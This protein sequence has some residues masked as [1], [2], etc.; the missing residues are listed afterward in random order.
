MSLST[1]STLTSETATTGISDADGQQYRFD[2]RPTWTHR[3][4]ERSTVGLSGSYSQVNY[5]GVDNRSLTDYRSGVV[6]L[7]ADRRLTEVAGLAVDI[8]YGRFRTKGGENDTENLAVQVGGE[9]R[10]SETLGLDALVGLRQTEAR[11]PGLAG[12]TVSETSSGP[13]YTVGVEKRLARGGGLRLRAARDLTPSGSAEVLDTTS[14]ELGYSYPVN[15]RLGLDFSSRAFRNRLP[16]GEA[17]RSD[18]SYVGA[19]MGLTYRFSPSWRLGLSYWYRWQ[20]YEEDPSS[21]ESNQLALTLGW[22]DR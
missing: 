9:Y 1:Q 22:T 18:R 11:F 6:A 8:S 13:V 4:S 7:G 17:S 16:S 12:R 2:L 3:L 19:R 5:D 14:L 15:E 21:A 20:E 10:L